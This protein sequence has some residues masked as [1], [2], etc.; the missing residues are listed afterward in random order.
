M[1]LL[2]IYY[3]GGKNRDWDKNRVCQRSSNIPY[4]L[5]FSGRDDWI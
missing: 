4:L 5:A 3:I 1:S 2:H